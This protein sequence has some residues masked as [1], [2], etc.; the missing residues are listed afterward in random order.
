[1]KKRF[2]LCCSLAILPVMA[3]ESAVPDP[4]TLQ[5]RAQGVFKLLPAVP[6]ELEH[7]DGVVNQIT[8]E[9]TE[10]GK[11]LFFEPR[12]SSSWF[13]SCNTC[14]NLGLAGVD[15]LPTSIGHHW[16]RG[17]RNAPTVYNAVF[18][19][20]QFWDG[21][22][23]GLAEQAGGPIQNPVEMASDPE[24]VV[25]T[26]KSIPE[27][28]ERFKTAFPDQPEPVSFEN[29]TMA[30]EAFE[31]HLLTPN[32]AF[33]RF[34][35]GDLKA[36]DE[37]E[38]AGLALFMDKGC[39]GCHSGENVGGKGY[40]KFG[41]MKAP[42]ANILPPEDQGRFGVTHEVS[43][44][45]LFKAPSLR[46]VALT[47]PYFHSGAVDSLAEAVNVMASAQLNIELSPQ[48]VE[49]ITAF[50]HTLNGEFPKVEYPILPPSTPDTP[51]PDLEI[52]PPAP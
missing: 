14:H 12:L 36:L 42:E 10:L 46:N 6:G 7:K 52:S 21:R 11:M 13:V 25:A 16:Q 19:S 2:L 1:M 37:Q 3:Q 34:L 49:D 27:Y 5:Q 41:V 50:L 22:A 9:K 20:A 17:P 23:A 45:Y 26:L 15:L 18:N 48:E 35:G 40:F 38:Q 32:S 47:P 4:E 51:P 29:V 31:A 33:D 28:Q 44:Q 30:I 43:D 24:R 39:A 8:P